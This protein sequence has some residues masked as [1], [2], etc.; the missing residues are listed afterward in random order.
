MGSEGASVED[1][2]ASLARGS[3]I[4]GPNALPCTGVDSTPHPTGNPVTRPA[5]VR[6]ETP[7]RN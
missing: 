4:P 1:M 2:K 7:R 3:D 5:R 6:P